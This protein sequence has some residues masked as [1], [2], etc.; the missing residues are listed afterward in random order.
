[1]LRDS[2]GKSK[3]CAFVTYASKQFAIN[4]IKALHHSQTME[5]STSINDGGNTS[6][7]V[8]QR[9]KSVLSLNSKIE[10]TRK[11]SCNCYFKM[12]ETVN[13]LDN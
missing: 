11:I 12:I 4:A 8:L 1:M 3:A 7:N 5:V 6:Y 10:I 13:S 9:L 2:T